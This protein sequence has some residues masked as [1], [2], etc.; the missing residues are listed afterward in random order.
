MPIRRSLTILAALV[1]IAVLVT[2]SVASGRGTKT[3]EV[4]DDFF[5]PTKLEIKKNDRVKF[6]WTGT[7]EHDIVKIKGPGKFFESG[8]QSGPGVHFKRKFEDKGTYKLI[9]SLHDQ[10]RMKVEVG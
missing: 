2:A 4:G 3:V 6:N 8:P 9:C 1:A 5:A 7:N 10:M